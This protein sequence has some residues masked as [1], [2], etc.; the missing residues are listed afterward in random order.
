MPSFD[1][2][3]DDGLHDLHIRNLA[4]RRVSARRGL[5][6]SIFRGRWLRA[7]LGA[8]C[9]PAWGILPRAPDGRGDRWSSRSPLPPP[10]ATGCSAH[11]IP[12]GFRARRPESH[13]GPSEAPCP[14]RQMPGRHSTRAGS[15]ARS[16]GI[17]AFLRLAGPHRSVRVTFGSLGSAS[18]LEA[19][20]WHAAGD[21]PHELQSFPNQGSSTLLSA[22]SILVSSL[23]PV[24]IRRYAACGPP[25]GDRPQVLASDQPVLLFL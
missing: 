22:A 23:G 8:P 1:S 7:I 11:G 21:P 16:P 19:E 10:S 25:F 12:R 24:F 4:T 2:F 9:H 14:F 18:G 3:F 20:R 17:G 13:P 6:G 5:G 15:V